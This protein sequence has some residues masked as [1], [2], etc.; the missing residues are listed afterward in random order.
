V[1]ALTAV[2][3][4]LALY[5]WDPV[6]LQRLELRTVDARFSVRGTD[7]PSPGPVVIAV[8]DKTFARLA[9]GA[10][11]IPRANYGRMLDVLRNARPAVIAIDVFFTK[12][13]TP[14]ENRALLRAIR[15]TNRPIVLAYK[16]FTV[17][18]S[19]VHPVLFGGS[20][21][22]YAAKNVGTGIVLLPEDRDDHNRRAD[23]EVGTTA[24]PTAAT[25]AFAAADVAR[26]GRLRP[27][28]L[29]AAPRRAW[30]G[31]SENTTWI[32][33]RGPPGTIRRVSALDVLHGDIPARTFAGKVVVIGVIARENT[34]VHQTPLDGG[35]DMPGPEVQANAI[36][37]I[38][39]GVPLRDVPRLVDILAILALACIPALASLA[40]SRAVG[41]AAIAALTVV[42]LAA[43]QLAFN[44][45]WIV[46][47]VLPLVALGV[48]AA[49]VAVLVTARMVRRRRRASRTAID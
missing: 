29:P 24:G 31:Q 34:D 4:A 7:A 27:D 49:C 42:F 33:F 15:A 18:D 40:A 2:A 44:T 46:A 43:A 37:T 38:L 16:D 19:A 13:Q 12:A 6:P 47:V 41:V 28:D 1:I 35:H 36:D 48:S 8:D 30:G 3:L 20:A 10:T 32:D 14:Q 17:G 21:R 39:R 5:V 25:F 23:Y 9:P 11:A 26:H 22:P 45:G